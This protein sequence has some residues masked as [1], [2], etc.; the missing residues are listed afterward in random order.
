MPE[1]GGPEDVPAREQALQPLLRAAEQGGTPIRPLTFVSERPAHDIVDVARVKG[2]RLVVMGW[3][4]PVV[5]NKILGGVVNDVMSH[6]PATVAVYVQRSTTSWRRVLVPYREPELDAAALDAAL[7]IASGN[8]VELTVLRVVPEGGEK[9][10]E[11]GGSAGSRAREVLP[12]AWR[13]HAVAGRVVVRVVGSDTPVDAV[14]EEVRR[15]EHDL[16]VIGVAKAWGLT[17][18]FFGVRHERIVEETQASLL[19]V[20][21]HRPGDA[22][23]AEVAAAAE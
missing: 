13:E 17:P 6:A 2:A 20:R 3:H 1:L 16:V 23:R 22:P 14:V 8:D 12:P 4:K 15:G 11:L 10:D 5:S 7:R 18:A 19:I 21:E 9:P